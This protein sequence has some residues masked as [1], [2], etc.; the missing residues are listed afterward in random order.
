MAG[1][2]LESVKEVA[3]ALTTKE[4]EGPAGLREREMRKPDSLVALSDHEMVMELW[5]RR[6]AVRL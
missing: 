1:E 2:R 3:L 5:N 4:V 6:M